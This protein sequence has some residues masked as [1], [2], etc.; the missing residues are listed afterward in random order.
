MSNEVFL[1]LM[2]VDKKVLDGRLR[3]IINV[4]HG[5]SAIFDDITEE[6]VKIAIDR[7]RKEI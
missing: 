3:L 4:S 2:A 1:Q 7:C 6:S 5:K